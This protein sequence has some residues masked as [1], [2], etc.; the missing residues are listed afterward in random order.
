MDKHRKGRQKDFV[1][2]SVPGG[3]LNEVKGGSVQSEV[4]EPKNRPVGKEVEKL[5]NDFHV[6]NDAV[7]G[8]IARVSDLEALVA[9]LTDRLNVA[10]RLFRDYTERLD[11]L[12]ASDGGEEKK[13]E[14]E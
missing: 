4:V 3:T 9:V 1:P 11:A 7:N 8:L 6:L 14:K 12:E 2:L 13:V 10:S 5:G